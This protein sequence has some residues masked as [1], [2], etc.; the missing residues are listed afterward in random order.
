MGCGWPG[1]APG[2]LWLDL[3][4]VFNHLD[5]SP[6]LTFSTGH[7]ELSGQHREILQLPSPPLPR[8]MFGEISHRENTIR[9][10][11][12]D[13]VNVF[14]LIRIMNTIQD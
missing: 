2:S 13:L 3:S 9:M 6:H 11:F 7:I 10:Y 8:T 1:E 4:I 5:L 14:A 12:E